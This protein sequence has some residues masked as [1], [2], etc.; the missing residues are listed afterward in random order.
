[1]SS[2][3]LIEQCATQGGVVGYLA[4][5]VLNARLECRQA[6]IDLESLVHPFD[7]VYAS[8]DRDRFDCNNNN[9][10]E[11]VGGDSS[12]RCYIDMPAPAGTI[13]YASHDIIFLIVLNYVRITFC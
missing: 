12:L 5:C 8:L 11:R 9:T 1:M 10:I 6:A 2:D 3:D 4:N 7:D 13:S